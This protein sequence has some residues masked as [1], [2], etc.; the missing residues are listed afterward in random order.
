MLERLRHYAPYAW[1]FVV[2]RNAG[3]LIYGLAVTDRCNLS[4][5]GCH[6]SNNGP[7]DLP[8][9]RLT[10]M[11]RS[12]YD[13]GCRE[14]YF[15]GGE[16]MMWRDGARTIDDLIEAARRMGYFHVHVYTNGTLG[17]GCSADLVWV[18]VDGLPETYRTRRGDHFE[19]VESAIRAPGH[20][21][22]RVIYVIDRYTKDG[23]EEFLEWVR[24]ARLPVMGVMFYFHTPYYGYDDL[25]LDAAE[26]RSVI[27]E[28][29]A[30]KARGLPVANTRAG[31]EL[32]ASGDWPRRI[33]IALVADADGES[34]CCRAS[35]DVCADCGY[36][37]CT[38]IVAA[39]R[40]NPEAVMSMVG[41]V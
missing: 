28:L 36:S 35:D 8:F 2:R 38:E 34:V 4:C 5:R 40:L 1:R 32:L 25:F 27:G 30:M 19:E 16:P 17:L 23:V 13:R 41:Y 18:S 9:A 24:E 22:T 14:L 6:V 39:Q 26:R 21:P 31:L 10:D 11:A 3:P 33:P 12:A 15:T 29:I 7:G 37:P 20:P